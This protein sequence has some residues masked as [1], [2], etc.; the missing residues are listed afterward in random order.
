[1]KGGTDAYY[2]YVVHLFRF[3][4]SVRVVGSPGSTRGTRAA[5]PI[6][7]RSSSPNIGYIVQCSRMYGD[8][9]TV[10]P[11]SL[12]MLPRAELRVSWRINQSGIYVHIKSGC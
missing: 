5:Q 1:M 9:T 3:D 10:Q 7:Y 4:R 8:R 6:R 11:E 2:S 12:Y